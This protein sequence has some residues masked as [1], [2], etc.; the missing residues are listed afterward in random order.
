LLRTLKARGLVFP[1][2]PFDDPVLGGGDK[3][4]GSS[5]VVALSHGYG[6]YVL[7]H[8][9][10]KPKAFR[11]IRARQ[12]RLQ[13]LHPDFEFVVTD[14]APTALSEAIALKRAHYHRSRQPDV[15]GTSWVRELL[16]ALDTGNP[17]ATHLQVSTL[18]IEGKMVASHIG[19]RLAGLL[20]YWLP[21]YDPAY[22]S[23]SPGLLLLHEIASR[24]DGL[25]EI[26]LGGGGDY[27][28]K[29]EFANAS[30]DFVHAS[31]GAARP[32]AS[33]LRRK[34]IRRL[35]LVASLQEPVFRRLLRYG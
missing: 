28:F 13:E 2:V 33:P 14:R 16:R 34:V 25:S 23:C 24:D 4:D 3:T 9:K 19:L 12:R 1:F 31:L 29:E 11:N 18:R 10:L 26:D 15:L 22:G 20:H 27:R 35:E 21:A 32:S 8:A 17:Q 30:H 6:R 7:D 5:A